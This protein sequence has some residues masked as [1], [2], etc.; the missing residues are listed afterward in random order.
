VPLRSPDG[1]VI[2]VLGVYEDF[3]ERSAVEAQLRKLSLAVEQSS[4]SIVITDLRWRID[5]VNEAF[6][7]SSGYS[8]EDAPWAQPPH[9]A[10]GRTAPRDLRPDVDGAVAGPGLA[11]RVHQPSPGRAR[12]LS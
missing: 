9:A 11:R 5:Y 6:V 1:E 3:T 10:V 4:E 12:D 7:Q 2:G 8:R